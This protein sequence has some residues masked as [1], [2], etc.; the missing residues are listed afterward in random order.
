ML[1]RS[2]CNTHIKTE[3]VRLQNRANPYVIRNRTTVFKRRKRTILKGKMERVTDVLFVNSIRDSRMVAFD[4]LPGWALR[5]G[6]EVWRRRLHSR[7]HSGSSPRTWKATQNSQNPPKCAYGRISVRV[8]KYLLTGRWGVWCRRWK[9]AV[10]ERRWRDVWLWTSVQGLYHQAAL[11]LSSPQPPIYLSAHRH[12]FLFSRSYRFCLPVSAN[13]T[14]L[15]LRKMNQKHG[16]TITL[17]K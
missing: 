17:L 13:S 7:F 1:R 10:A 6:R 15:L 4:V 9:V 3:H 14:K 5:S 11:C 2:L 12:V 8:Y 16:F